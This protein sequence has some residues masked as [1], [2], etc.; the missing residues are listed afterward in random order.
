MAACQKPT[1]RYSVPW[2]GRT[3]HPRATHTPSLIRCPPPSISSQRSAAAA[4]GG[5]SARS[6]G[7]AP[8][9]SSSSSSGASHTTT[10]G[11]TARGSGAAAGGPPGSA[12]DIGSTLRPRGGGRATGPCPRPLKW[13]RFKLAGAGPSAND[14]GV[15]RWRAREGS[16]NCHAGF[17]AIERV[18]VMRSESLLSHTLSRAE[19]K[20][21]GNV[22]G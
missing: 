5:T 6:G 13:G 7:S 16:S 17:A 20:R 21:T 3:S 12:R 15:R 2:N 18:I 11:A 1:G 4:M 19:K 8:R 22:W 10:A 14:G 9:S